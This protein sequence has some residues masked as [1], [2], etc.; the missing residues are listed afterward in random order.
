MAFV[1]DTLSKLVAFDR[2]CLAAGR[3]ANVL[4]QDT[5]A[6][7]LL[8][9]QLEDEGVPERQFWRRVALAYEIKLGLLQSTYDLQTVAGIENEHWVARSKKRDHSNPLEDPGALNIAI[10][11]A[12]AAFGLV[13]RTRALWDKL[14]LFV[15]ESYSPAAFEAVIRSK[16]SRKRAF[17]DTFSGGVGPISSDEVSGYASS[18]ERLDSGFRTP[19]LHG[20][21]S[22]RLWAFEP[23]GQWPVEGSS[24]LRGHWNA[25]NRAVNTVFRDVSTG[26]TSIDELEVWS[27]W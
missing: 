9:A 27:D 20:H 11:R 10:K 3:A 15:G 7:R 8:Y 6:L 23:I 17:V 22:I 16:K 18:V 12:R 21:G 13:A 5:P 25:M 24:K 14:F 26:T 4:V 2:N 1:L 19:E